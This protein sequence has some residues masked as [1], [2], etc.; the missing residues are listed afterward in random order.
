MAVSPQPKPSANSQGSRGFRPSNT[1]PSLPARETVRGRGVKHRGPA[2]SAR[3]PNP[4]SEPGDRWPLVA[5]GALPSLPTNPEPTA[6]TMRWLPTE[7]LLK[8][9]FLGLILFAARQH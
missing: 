7:Y 5:V 2:L 9:V 3:L 4:G 1:S 8:R 6:R